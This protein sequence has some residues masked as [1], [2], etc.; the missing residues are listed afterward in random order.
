MW[1]MF[2]D[3]V[4]RQGAS[5]LQTAYA[6]FKKFYKHSISLEGTIFLFIPIYFLISIDMLL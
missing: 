4:L 2:Q 6:D 5:Q 3:F 1:V